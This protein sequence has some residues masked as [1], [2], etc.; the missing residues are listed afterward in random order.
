MG[1][2]GG[3]LATDLPCN[4]GDTGPTPGPGRCHVLQGGYG[5]EPVRCNKRSHCNEKPTCHNQ[6]GALSA[7]ASRGLAQ[8][9]INRS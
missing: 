2:P 1:F 9:E 8:P 6:R 4:A 5:L 7:A 3:P